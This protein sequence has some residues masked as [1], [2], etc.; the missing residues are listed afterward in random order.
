MS[1]ELDKAIARFTRVTC[2]I[3][4]IGIKPSLDEKYD[5]ITGLTQ[6]H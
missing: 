6:N 4:D 3:L 1:T 5:N 2:E